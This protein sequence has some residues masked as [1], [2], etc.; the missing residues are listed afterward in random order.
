MLKLSLVIALMAPTASTASPGPVEAK[1]IASVVTV[2]PDALQW[3]RMPQF[4]D[5][6]ERVVLV[7]NP[8]AGGDWVYRVRVPQPIRVEAHTHPVDEYITVLEGNWLFG[9]GTVFDAAKLVSY[10]PGSFVRIPANTPHF[11]ATGKGVVIIQSSGSGIFTTSLV[12][13][14]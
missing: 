5:G 4:A 9:L 3:Q 1:P 7:G 11:V 13:Q 8:E 14:P 10:P 2:T 12:K 6:R